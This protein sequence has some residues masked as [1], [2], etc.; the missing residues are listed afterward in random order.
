MIGCL[1]IPF[2]FQA[3]LLQR[4]DLPEI[5]CLV[6]PFVKEVSVNVSILTLTVI[7][8]DRYYAIVRPLKPGWS[9]RKASVIVAVVWAVSVVSSLPA[10]LTDK[11]ESYV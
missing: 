6:A 7:S 1:S 5:L 3:A 8:V 4:W 2:Q 10:M 9:G 11:Y